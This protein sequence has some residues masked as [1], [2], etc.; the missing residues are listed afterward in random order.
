MFDLHP[1]LQKIY[2]FHFFNTIA[3]SVV[4]NFLFLDRIFL[5]MGL[6][7][8]QFGAIKGLS[9]FIPMAINLLLSPFIGKL[10]KDRE[11]V[12]IGYFIRVSLPLLFLLLPGCINDKSTLVAAVTG[13]L[14]T[15]HIFPIIS[16]NCIQTLVRSNVPQK[17]LGK[18]LSW[19]A[20][21]W[22]LPGFLLA[23]PL[24][25]ILDLHSNGSDYEFY[26]TMFFIMISTGS[27]EIIASIIIMRLPREHLVERPVLKVGDIFLPFK[28]ESFG[29]LLRAILVFSLLNSMV[30]A[31]INPYLLN[32][33]K[34]SMT[35]ISIISAVVS[36]LS[37][38]VLPFWGKLADHVGGKNIY[39]MA[40][41]GLAVGIFAL[42]GRGIVFILVYA[43]FSWE[44]SRGFFGSGVYSTQQFMI[45][46]LSDD[47]KRSVFFA[48]ATFVFGSGWFLGSFLGGILLEML[49]N[50]Q[51]FSNPMT[52]YRIF[53]GING[54]GLLI[55]AR[56]TRSLKDDRKKRNAKGMAVAMYRTARTL[57]GRAR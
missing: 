50:I 49:R 52:A 36:I 21:V 42:L 47:K 43:L 11:I 40:V 7:M 20:V 37:I 14:V 38:L 6:N 31:F 54:T 53:F 44:G 9:Y 41:I 56:I 35:L 26:R 30:M 19:I 16:N 15:V 18:H 2:L 27:F 55:L 33:Q 32:V 39:G 48:A 17:V 10:N 28:N 57:F 12:G 4:A 34:I 46:S 8:Q 13:I 3:I 1:N 22:T 23:I 5:R 24:S 45:F 29:K 25:R 51:S